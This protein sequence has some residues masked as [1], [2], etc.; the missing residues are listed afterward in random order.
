MWTTIVLFLMISP[1]LTVL[2]LGP[3]KMSWTYLDVQR[4]EQVVPPDVAVVAGWQQD[5]A[6]LMRYSQNPQAHYYFLLDWPAA[7]AGPRAFV[8]DYHLMQ[9]YRNNGYYAKNIQDSQAFLCSRIL[10]S[11]CWTPRT[12]ARST[13]RNNDSPDMQKPN[14][15]D[16]NIGT[17]PQFE[18]KVIDSFDGTEAKRKLIAVHRRASL[19]FCNPQ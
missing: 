14:W 15:F 18:W 3:L 10:I 16:T 8:L 19:A 17:T 4:L 6:K 7:L 12:Q 11:S 5:F 2:A 13:A 9:A 1:V